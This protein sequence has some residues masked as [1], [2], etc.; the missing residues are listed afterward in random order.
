MY[1][2]SLNNLIEA[3]KCLPSVGEKTAERFAFSI[4]D[5][6]DDQ[7]ELL[8]DSLEDVRTKV[9]PCAKCNTLTE[10]EFCSICTDSTRQT[11]VLCV[12]EDVKSVFLFEKIG[13]FKGKYHVLNGLISPLDGINPEDI[14]ID[15][16]LDRVHEEHFDEI[17][18]AFKPSIE[19]ETTALYI[20]KILDGLNI[21][22]TKLANGVPI[23]ADMEYIDSLTLERA[24]NDRKEIS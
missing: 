13:M 16:L 7:I 5:F 8:K 17:I 12:V 21:K 11:N 20:K 15:K 10:D 6:D 2:S 22:I 9:H 3:F 1:P 14:G 19:G 23:G 24:L 18:F 4:F